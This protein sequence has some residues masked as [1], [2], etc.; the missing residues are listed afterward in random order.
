MLNIFLTKANLIS[1]HFNIFSHIVVVTMFSSDDN[2]AQNL[3]LGDGVTEKYKREDLSQVNP[4]LYKWLAIINDK[5]PTDSI[6]S[7]GNDIVNSNVR[8]IAE[9]NFVNLSDKYAYHYPLSEKQL[10]SVCRTLSSVIGVSR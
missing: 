2:Y 7:Q 6:V 3:I 4:Q 1:H 8:K 9:L 10:L 5:S